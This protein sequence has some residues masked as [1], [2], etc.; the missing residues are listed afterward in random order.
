VYLREIEGSRERYERVRD[1]GGDRSL[2]FPDWD[3]PTSADRTLVY[4]KGAYVLHLL[5]EEMGEDA[6]WDGVRHYTRTYFGKS[7]TTPDFRAAMVESVGK[8]LSA[9]FDEWVYLK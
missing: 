3:R 5:R 7:V 1:E 9:F 6:F 2:V 8:D 4:R